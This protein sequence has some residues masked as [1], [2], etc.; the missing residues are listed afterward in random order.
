MEKETIKKIF[1]FLEEK[2]GME[3]P[4]SL[5]ISIEKLKLIQNLENHPDGTQ[6]RYNGVLDLSGSN[7]TKLPSDLYV[8]GFLNFNRC[9]QLTELPTKLHVEGGL[10]L[11]RTTIKKLPDNL[12]VGGT[13][14]LYGTKI[15]DIPNNLYVG[16][17]LHIENAPLAN[18]Y[19]DDEIREIV[20]ST[21]GEI[22]GKIYR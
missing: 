10:N 22:R 6:Y 19:K 9:Q 5:L 14:W 21:S 12:Y 2:E 7:I 3:I 13:L 15:Q 17:N 4:H 18:K 11:M 20:V 1:D 8:N 16:L